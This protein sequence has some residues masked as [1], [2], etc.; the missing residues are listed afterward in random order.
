MHTSHYTHWAI[1]NS[2][3]FGTILNSPWN[4][5]VFHSDKTHC[6]TQ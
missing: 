6:W 3:S 5:V 1:L 4:S 2:H